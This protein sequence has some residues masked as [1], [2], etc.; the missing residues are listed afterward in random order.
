MAQITAGI[1]SVLSSPVIYDSLQLI[2]GASA[3]RAELVEKYI[4]PAA[5]ARILDIG[6]GTAEILNHLP[7]GVDY[8]GFDISPAYIEAA[9]R[10]YADRGRFFCGL[11][12]AEQLDSL[13][14]FDIVVAIG[15][16]HHLNDDEAM[17]VFALART[18]LRPGGRIVTIDPCLA[19]GQ[20]PLARLLISQDRGQNVRTS[21]GYRR[22]G[23]PYF[24][25]VTGRLRHRAWI[26]YTHWIM[27]CQS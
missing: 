19:E 23:E 7:A 2:M 21:D 14:R 16:L 1:R 11:L 10:R 20:N 26:P 4:R 3:V 25:S 8:T 9:T 5:D 13:P 22:L 17:Q 24:A 6:C 12:T 27:E 15:V 18:A